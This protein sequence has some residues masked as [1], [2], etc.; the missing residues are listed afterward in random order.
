[1]AIGTVLGDIILGLGVNKGSDLLKGVATSKEANNFKELFEKAFQQ[2]FTLY[3]DRTR[4]F[5]KTNI[6]K[7][8]RK[9][10]TEH[11][12]YP[13]SLFE[14]IGNIDIDLF[15]EL[16]NESEQRHEIAK[17][18]VLAFNIDHKH[19]LPRHS[20][21]EIL[22]ECLSYFEEALDSNLELGTKV[23]LAYLE[24]AV[25]QITHSHTQTALAPTPIPKK[26]THLPLLNLKE[27]IG[28]DE[29]LKK[30]EA[31]MDNSNNSHKIVLTSGMGGIGKTTL[32]QA[33]LTKHQDQFQHIAWLTQNTEQ[34]EDIFLNDTAFL[35]ALQLDFEGSQLNPQQ[36]LSLVFAAMRQLEQPNQSNLLVIDNA[37]PDLQKLREI[38]TPPHWK[39]LVTSRN[40]IKGYEQLQLG[41]L[42]EEAAYQLF[43]SHYRQPLTQKNITIVQNILRA[44]GFH[45]LSIELYAKTAQHLNIPLSRL[46]RKL[47]NSLKLGYPTAI[48]TPHEQGRTIEQVFSYLV[49][50]FELGKLSEKEEKLLR[51][52]TLLPP[53][54][55][56]IDL[57]LNLWGLDEETNDVK[58]YG[59]QSAVKKLAQ[60]GWLNVEE[61]ENHRPHYSMHRVIREVLHQKW[62]MA[63][64]EEEYLPFINSVVRLLDEDNH[65]VSLRSYLIPFGENLLNY[66]DL[67]KH[68]WLLVA[69]AGA[70][71][72]IN[73]LDNAGEAYQEALD[74]RRTLAKENPQAFL[75]AVATTLNNLG[76]LHSDKNEF[77]P[78]L[79]AYQEALDIRRTLAKENPQAFL[80]Y[81]ATT[82]NS[83]GN[84]QRAKNE[85]ALALE[86]Y[87][88]ALDIRRTSAKENPQ[89]FLPD[90]ATTL[91]NLGILLSNKN[92]F[93]AALEAYQEALDIRRTLAKENPQAFLPDVAVT[94]NNL[95]VLHSDKNEFAPALEAYQEAL[96]IRRTLAKENPQAFLP[97]VA[98]TLN[99]LG[100]FTKG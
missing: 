16:Q 51:L 55:V 39:V 36:R 34:A 98:T 29:D 85:F 87:Q 97:D 32:A 80:P 59:Y 15:K 88:E 8:I 47:Q 84:L 48:Q 57:V 91:N 89:A 75:P 21:A 27:V 11:T 100:N 70:Y 61:Q 53:M 19:L 81:V 72:K 24:K 99:N 44:L 52:W 49:E 67:Q 25:K 31:L 5:V 26:L 42:S 2:S 76:I 92:E 69:L 1:M 56:W 46:E 38:P 7:K 83:L 77:A 37:T 40:Q 17:K 82:L 90:V 96:D 22:A 79:E 74:I 68:T 60:K 54:F 4:N 9:Q 23:I 3:L 6:S 43:L 94:L 50:I 78:A 35:K 64:Y 86:A 95:A 93:A 12:L 20:N 62:K 41:Y 33:Y 63:D 71:Q 58:W 18:I 66:L 10:I 30:L 14:A 65:D 13:R 28:R 73:R 45:T